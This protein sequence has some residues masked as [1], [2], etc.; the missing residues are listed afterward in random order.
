MLQP[1]ESLK[2]SLWMDEA[3]IS[4]VRFGDACW[5]VLPPSLEEVTVFPD[6]I[7]FH[8]HSKSS[9]HMSKQYVNEEIGDMFV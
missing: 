7:S 6:K 2:H 3:C 4:N 8:I 5:P 1:L 9:G